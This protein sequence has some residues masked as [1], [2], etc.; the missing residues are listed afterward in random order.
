M[1]G[2]VIATKIDGS[3]RPLFKYHLPKIHW[4]P[5]ETGDTT[6]GV[7][8]TNGCIGGVEFW[9]EFKQTST[10]KVNMR[11]GQI[12]WIHRRWRHGGRVWIA[13]RQ[14]HNGG[15][16]LGEPIDDLV[17]I[18]GGHVLELAEN[19][20]QLEL[21]MISGRWR[22]GPRRWGWSGIQALLVGANNEHI[23]YTD[24]P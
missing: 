16:R 7:P 9:V 20:L 23:I 1:G 24:G 2:H 13:V 6:S 3:L 8:D 19:G 11:P 18:Y 22:G 15:P 5:I 4:T 14:R 21:S 17:M 10:N 12:G